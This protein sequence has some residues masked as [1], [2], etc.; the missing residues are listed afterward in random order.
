MSKIGKKNI[1]IPKE[2]SIKKIEQATPVDLM[3]IETAL[4]AKGSLSNS[5]L[6]F[7]ERPEQMTMAKT[8]AE[9][10]NSGIGDNQTRLI[11]EA[12]TGVGKSLAYLLPSVIYALKNNK[13]NICRF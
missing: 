6:R 7:E 1:L 10:I 2:S 3:L 11:V 8:I 5:M 13:R 9:T 4:S 12:G